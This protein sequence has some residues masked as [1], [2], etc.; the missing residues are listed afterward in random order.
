MKRIFL[1]TAIIF[2]FNMANSQTVDNKK[3]TAGR[4]QLGSLAPKF[5]ELNDDVLFGQVWSRETELSARD[6][7]LVTIVSLIA[8][9]NF[10]HL[11]FH[12]QKGK[13]NGLSQQEIVEIITHQAFYSG[14]PKAWSAFN[15]VKEVYNEADT[16]KH[17]PLFP[18]GDK[19]DA[20]AK[21][22]IGQ[23]YLKTLASPDGDVDVTVANV[24]FEPA[25]RNNWH[26][27]KTDYQ[28]LLVTG[29]E[30]WYQ[31]WGKPAQLL[32]PGDT[33]VIRKGI[34]HWHGATANSWFSHIAVTK[35]TTEW[36]ETVTDEEYNNLSIK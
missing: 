30:G 20:Y 5:A 17:S 4:D 25:C 7:S 33:V 35:G 24:T 32:K 28:I 11:K 9:G 3:V 29:G 34:K 6:R 10:E 13:D 21:Y 31:E 23:S 2:S 19:N 15:I 27:H 16:A 1:I 18:L 26:V 22:F 36:N 12:L 14:W 8:G